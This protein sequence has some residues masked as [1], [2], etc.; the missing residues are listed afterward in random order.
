MAQPAQQVTSQKNT[1]NTGAFPD[2]GAV[3]GIKA[4]AAYDGI[5]DHN[6]TDLRAWAK[7]L[8]Q[9]CRRIVL[10]TTEGAY[11]MATTASSGGSPTTRA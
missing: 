7:A 3:N 11:D 9:S 5:L 2:H 4:L 1:A 10:D 8:K 6:T